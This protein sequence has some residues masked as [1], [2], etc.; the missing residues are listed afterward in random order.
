MEKWLESLRK[1]PSWYPPPDAT[2]L[3]DR[4]VLSWGSPRGMVVVHLCKD[5]GWWAIHHEDSL[6]LLSQ[7]S[8]YGVVDVDYLRARLDAIHVT[9]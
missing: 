3:I 5:S 8:G 1:V 9:T 7:R 4:V 2:N 6:G